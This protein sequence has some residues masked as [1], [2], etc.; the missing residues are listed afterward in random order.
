MTV[1]VLAGCA[2]EGEPEIAATTESPPNIILIVTDDMGYTDIG[3]FGSEIETP[4]LDRL[5]YAGVRLTN[6][7]AS[8][9]CAPTR[10]MLMSGADNHTAGMGSMFGPQ[11]YVGGYEDRPGYERY[12]H[13][14]VASM[15][16]RLSDAGYRTYMA[17]KW[18]LGADDEKK[19][20]ARGF[21]KAFALMGGHSS[22]MEMRAH[23]TA[24][25]REN[26]IALE[27]LP[28][29]FYSTNT[30]T[31]KLIEYIGAGQ[32]GGKPFFGYLALTAPHWPLQ[33]P[34]EYLDR[35]AGQYD[36]GFDALRERRV[37]K[38]AELGVVPDVDPALFELIGPSWDQFDEE[39]QKY[40]ARK[41]EIYAALMENMDDNIG[42]LISYL[43]GIGELDNT[44][45]F[46]MSDNG[47]ESDREDK[48][49]T[50]SRSI[51]RAGG[52]FDNSY[53][54]LGNI[55]SWV[56]LGPGFAQATAA[57]YRL[58]KGFL[59]E[60]GSRVTSFAWH[61]SL[62]SSASINNQYLTLMDVLPTFLDLANARFDERTYNGREVEPMQGKSFA[63]M[64]AG[65]PTPVHV[66]DEVIAFEL[67]G[68]RSLVRGDWKILW[69]QRAINIWWDDE[70]PDHWKSWR[71][72]NIA[73][74][75][76]EQ[77]DLSDSEPALREELIALWNDFAEENQVMK[78]VTPQWPAGP[79]PDP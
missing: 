69:E 63:G 39:E 32:D 22:H 53:E 42:R 24:V 34:S 38:A 79:L 35:Y 71:L 26:G 15:P 47:A 65:D 3:A 33:V 27:S 64:L 6:F 28:T 52:Y 5:A 36:D 62:A 49:L 51:A 31:D 78:S 17:G 2:P 46:F 43:E 45:I 58:F 23:N 10:A 70:E 76:T 18:H 4:N 16:E 12:L 11:F 72:Y 66:A 19:P 77:F 73:N 57:P 41:M 44:F 29:D 14:R 25:F 60:G 20:T 9:Q 74:D 61:P 30:Y 37:S 67:H 48:N 1:F 75:P 54:N 40:L 55:N 7:H 56:N 13:P 59:T 68:Q 8:P 50:F 21:D